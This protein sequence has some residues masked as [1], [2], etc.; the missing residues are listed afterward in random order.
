MSAA[1]RI[2]G[3]AAALL[4]VF[5]LSAAVGRAV[6]VEPRALGE[7]EGHAEQAGGAEALPAGLSVSVGGVTIVPGRTTFAAGRS[8]P[9][10]FR[11]EDERGE[12]VTGLD[13][14]HERRMHLIV[15]RRDLTG[16]QHLHPREL[17]DGSWTTPL[18]LEAPGSYRAFADFEIDGV[19]RTLGV[20]L[21]VPGLAGSAPPPEPSTRAADGPYAVALERDGPL[22]GFR[23]EREGAPVLPEPYL[24]ARGHLVVLREGDLAFV[25]AHPEKG[26]TATGGTAYEVEL[27]SAGRYALYLQFVHDGGLHTVRFTVEEHP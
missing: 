3:F 21:S 16:F 25:H 15:V 11:L 6:D 26:A 24:G 8:T 5:A 2:L 7:D 9:F 10:S 23:V 22:L 4:A 20:D 12:A 1:V 27:P 19:R 13:L 18:A 17:P 14:V